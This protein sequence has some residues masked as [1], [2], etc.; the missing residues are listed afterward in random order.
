MLAGRSGVVPFAEQTAPRKTVRDAIAALRRP[1]RSGDQLH[2][3]PE[4]RSSR[5]RDLIRAVPADGGGRLDLPENLTLD[6]H[7]ET[8]GFTDVY[9]RMAWDEV[10]P[11]ITGG[12][13]NPSKGRF[14]HPVQDRAITLREAALLQS[15]PPSYRFA[16]SRGKYAVAALI[17]N[18]L[19]PRFVRAHAR[20][21][22]KYL[23]ADIKMVDSG[24][25]AKH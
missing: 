1:G 3:L 9:G 14:L 2:D 13:I 16:L 25:H 5:I 11:T 15:F 12:C 23:L 4:N 24:R 21:V 20:E 18:A 22:A 17:G 19:P 6:C 10:A 7:Q 8:T